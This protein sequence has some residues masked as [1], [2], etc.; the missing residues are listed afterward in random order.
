[1]GVVQCVIYIYNGCSKLYLST[2]L[3]ISIMRMFSTFFFLFSF[4]FTCDCFGLHG[5]PMHGILAHLHFFG[6][7]Y[8]ESNFLIHDIT[9][10]PRQRLNIAV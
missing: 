10:Q 9:E 4:S 2:K 6:F 1:M 5:A 7:T 3:V 8:F